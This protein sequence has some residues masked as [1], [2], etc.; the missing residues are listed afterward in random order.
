MARNRETTVEEKGYTGQRAEQIFE[1]EEA[2]IETE[3]TYEEAMER[4]FWEEVLVRD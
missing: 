1:K 2:C 3:E 4:V